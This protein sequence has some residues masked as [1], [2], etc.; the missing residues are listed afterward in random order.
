MTG[1]YIL[2]LTVI[3]FPNNNSFRFFSPMSLKRSQK[4]ASFIFSQPLAASSL[5]L[6]G[7]T[8]PEFM[9][10]LSGTFFILPAI[11]HLLSTLFK[12]SGV[13]FLAC[14]AS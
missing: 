8:M 13:L 14:A 12:R 3:R 10:S 6:L 11:F 5:S 4:V 1:I 7:G 9:T 2:S